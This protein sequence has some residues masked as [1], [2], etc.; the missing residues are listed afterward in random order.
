MFATNSKKLVTSGK[1]LVALVASESQFRALYCASSVLKSNGNADLYGTKMQSIKTGVSLF[2]W[3]CGL[4][5]LSTLDILL[6]CFII[7]AKMAL[8]DFKSR[9]ILMQLFASSYKNLTPCL[10]FVIHILN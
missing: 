4:K 2:S 3:L 8:K 5:V 7:D 1:F 10:R 9:G 6:H